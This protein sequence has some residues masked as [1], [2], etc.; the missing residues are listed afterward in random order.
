[1]GAAVTRSHRVVALAAVGAGAEHWQ[2]YTRGAV[3]TTPFGSETITVSP[4]KTE[5]SLLVRRHYGTK[6]WQW[7]L[8]LKGLTPSV[9]PDG[10]ITF[11][12]PSGRPTDL[13]LLAPAVL[14]P[15]GANI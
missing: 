11:A 2:R 14:P 12:D 1:T 6:T 7:D 15:A 5:Q 9:A 13:R 10:S 3:R 8:G 4:R